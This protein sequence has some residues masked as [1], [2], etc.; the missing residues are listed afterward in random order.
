[1]NLVYIISTTETRMGVNFGIIIIT[2]VV[3]SHASTKQHAQDKKLRR[4]SGCYVIELNGCG[5]IVLMY[6]LPKVF[7]RSRENTY[8]QHSNSTFTLP[9]QNT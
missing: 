5:G 2:I 1:M 4:L 7:L 8:H 3:H 9:P 6:L